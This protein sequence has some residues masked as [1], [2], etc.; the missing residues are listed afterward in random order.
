MPLSL[1]ASMTR[2]KP[3]VRFRS[4]S[5]AMASA[6][7]AAVS[8]IVPSGAVAFLRSESDTV[9]GTTAKVNMGA[10]ETDLQSLGSG[11][12]RGS[13]CRARSGR[14]RPDRVDRYLRGSPFPR[15]EKRTL[16]RTLLP[17]RLDFFGIHADKG[18]EHFF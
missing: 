4:A 10:S 11:P 7:A 15:P 12:T 14:M 9:C 8:N 5:V 16:D 3:S 13:A 6:V 18:T 1:S 17:G 2:R